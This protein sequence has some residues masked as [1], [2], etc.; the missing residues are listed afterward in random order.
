[1]SA[2]HNSLKKTVYFF[3]SLSD[4]FFGHFYCMLKKSEQEIVFCLMLFKIIALHLQNSIILYL[5]TQSVLYPC[6][7][8]NGY[9]HVQC[10]LH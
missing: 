7:H 5:H 3:I 9:L 4:F 6:K 10:K 2:F 1:M 8:I